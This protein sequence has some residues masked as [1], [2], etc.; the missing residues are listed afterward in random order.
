MSVDWRVLWAHWINWISVYNLK[1]SCYLTSP[2]CSWCH[3]RCCHRVSCNIHPYI[4]FALSRCNILMTESNYTWRNYS[5]HQRCIF[6]IF[7]CWRTNMLWQF[8]YLFTLIN[9]RFSRRIPARNFAVSG[10]LPRLSLLAWLDSLLIRHFTK[11][12]LSYSSF[13]ISVVNSSKGLNFALKLSDC[14]PENIS[15]L[16]ITVLSSSLKIILINY[17]PLITCNQIQSRWIRGRFE[18]FTVSR[19]K[20]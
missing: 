5:S 4:R 2:F 12:M 11:R 13:P 10:S 8:F 17:A 7:T 15:A 19:V 6:L 20:L 16:L 3:I 9:L 18:S 1:P 14:W